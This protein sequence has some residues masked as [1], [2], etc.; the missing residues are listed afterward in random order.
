MSFNLD[1]FLED[2]FEEKKFLV[3]LDVG[4]MST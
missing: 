4:K 2:F 1:F 3:R